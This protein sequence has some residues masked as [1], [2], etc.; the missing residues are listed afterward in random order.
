MD[1]GQGTG[2]PA[3]FPACRQR[4]EP[5][6]KHS[7]SL[8]RQMDTLGK[9]TCDSR[10][11]ARHEQVFTHHGDAPVQFSRCLRMPKSK[12]DTEKFKDSCRAGTG[13][14]SFPGMVCGKQGAKGFP[15]TFSSLCCS[16]QTPYNCLYE[17]RGGAA[18][19]LTRGYSQHPQGFCLPCLCL[20][21]PGPFPR[22]GA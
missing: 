6:S 10:A 11:Q 7:S 12:K 16:W 13:A 14:R 19:G 21:P 20:L 5:A 8:D 2:S 3:A 18:E 4:A 9:S 15:G 22:E 1:V 17:G